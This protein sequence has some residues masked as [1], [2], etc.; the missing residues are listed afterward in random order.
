IAGLG[1]PAEQQLCES[2]LAAVA[3]ARQSRDPAALDRQVRVL[4]SLSH[5]AYLRDPRSAFL[6]FEWYQ[7]RAAEATDPR[8]AQALL[9]QGR[10]L[11]KKGDEA[12]LRQLNRQ[13]DELFPATAENRRRSFGS[14]VR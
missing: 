13:L 7:S 11:A 14:G 12:G 5:A 8:R 9:E 10:K 6:T 1:T 3:E 2:A 4:R